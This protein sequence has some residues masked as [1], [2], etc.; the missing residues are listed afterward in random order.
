MKD[1]AEKMPII[2]G[3]MDL[4]SD[5]YRQIFLPIGVIPPQCDIK[6]HHATH[7]G[8]IKGMIASHSTGYDEA[9]QERLVLL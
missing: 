4:I 7:V 8:A 2:D 9:M 5:I 3:F 1:V 6:R